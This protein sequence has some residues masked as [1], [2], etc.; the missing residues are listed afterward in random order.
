MREF[1]LPPGAPEQGKHRDLPEGDFILASPQAG[2]GS[3]QWPAKYWSEL[4]ALL[5]LPLVMNG[6]PFAEEELAAIH[7]TRTHLSGISGLIHATRRARAVIGVDSG[8]MHLAAALN[9]PGVAI[10]GPTD[11][12]RNGPYG[13]SLQV[14]RD[15]S[16]VTDYSRSQEPAASMLAISPRMVADAITEILAST[17]IGK[18]IA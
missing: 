18:E 17:P 15:A 14:L 10:F 16:A 6:P 12:A 5:P 11:P 2:W 8:P 9:K 13:G 1:P 4:A 3:K 7:G